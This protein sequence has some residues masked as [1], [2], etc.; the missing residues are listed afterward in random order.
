MREALLTKSEPRDPKLVKFFQSLNGAI[1]F[2]AIVARGEVLWA[3]GMMSRACAYPTEDLKA[4]LIRAFNYLVQHK[5]LSLKYSKTTYF[6]ARTGTPKQ[7]RDADM[8]GLSG[9]ISIEGFSD[10]DYAAGPSVSGHVLSMAGGFVSAGSKKQS[11]TML[12]SASTELVAGSVAATF[13]IFM[14]NQLEFLGFPQTKPTK[15]WIDNKAT[16][17]LLHNPMSFSKVK[18]VAR[19]HHFLRECVENGDLEVSH[20]PT[21]FNVS[22]IFTKLVRCSCG[23]S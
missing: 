18:H 14:R 17:A 10:A 4:D 19:R 6:S 3:W 16:V 2:A 13:A 21:E 12:C 5:H 22:D 11:E 15:M 7:R 8:G 9:A 23:A 1:G 20:I